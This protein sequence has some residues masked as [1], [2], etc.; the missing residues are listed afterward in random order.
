MIFVVF[1]KTMYESQKPQFNKILQY[2]KYKKIKIQLDA[3]NFLNHRIY[4]KVRKKILK[5]I[6]LICHL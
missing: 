2:H 6:K 1:L 5:K 4:N 3:N